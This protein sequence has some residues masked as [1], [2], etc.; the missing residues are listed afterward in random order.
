MYEGLYKYQISAITVL[1]HSLN[2]KV[3]YFYSFFKDFHKE[4]SI[5]F[6][7]SYIKEVN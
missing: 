1:N 3:T 4:N 7:N 2:L 5:E 6:N